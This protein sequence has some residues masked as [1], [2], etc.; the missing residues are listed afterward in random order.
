MDGIPPMYVYRGGYASH[1]PRNFGVWWW[2]ARRGSMARMNEC[3]MPFEHNH[4]DTEKV[5]VWFDRQAGTA[6]IEINGAEWTRTD[7]SDQEMDEFM[8][9]CWRFGIVPVKD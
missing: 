4:T 5:N 3:S 9:Y 6:T 1:L 7:M 8:T 2:G